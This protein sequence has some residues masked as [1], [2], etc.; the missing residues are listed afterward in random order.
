MDTRIND[1][2]PRSNWFVGASYGGTDDQT[3][4]FLREGIWENGYDD[5]YLDLVRSMRPG[6]RI[7]IKSTYIR[8]HGLPF[9]NRG[10]LVSVMALKAI[11]TIT[12]NLND[13]K[14]VRVDWTKQEPPREWYFHTYRATIQP[15]VPGEWRADGLLAFAFEGKPQEID[16]FRNAP[17]WRE[18]FGGEPDKQRFL[19][20]KFYEA[21]ADKLLDY[22]DDRMNVASRYQ[23][24]GEGLVPSRTGEP[25][26]SS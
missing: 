22:R 2:E 14:R 24:V 5:K 20:T 16:C 9:E 18:R 25:L 8:K 13:G 26:F 23:G 12:E 10:N 7:A 19:W 11:G 6:D 3:P 15:V 17:F 4:R 1:K 21:I